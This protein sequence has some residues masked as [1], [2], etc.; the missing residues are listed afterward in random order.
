MTNNSPK[1]EVIATLRQIKTYAM[2]LA[3]SIRRPRF[4]YQA[5]G[6]KITF[7]IEDESHEIDPKLV[8][9]PRWKLMPKEITDGF[10]SIEA[11]ARVLI[12]TFGLRFPA[13][14]GLHLLPLS[15]VGLV[16]DQLD[17]YR[18]EFY[19]HRDNFL[20][21]LDNIKEEIREQLPEPIFN[22][23]WA[24]VPSRERLKGLFNIYC[25]TVPLGDSDVDPVILKTQM[26]L[27]DSLIADA[28]PQCEERL[29]RLQTFLQSLADP[30]KAY[31]HVFDAETKFRVQQAESYLRDNLRQF[32]DTL[33][34]EPRNV[35]KK[36]VLHLIDS[37][38]EEKII[39]K[40]TLAKI[41]QAFSMAE[42]FSFMNP[43]LQHII[44]EGRELLS[45]YTPR[46]INKQQLLSANL[47]SS[48][49]GLLERTM[50]PNVILSATNNFRRICT[51][52]AKLT[53]GTL[54]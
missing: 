41:E 18:Q 14:R 13:I 3:V 51:D 45:G 2:W 4:N 6:A 42:G 15:K 20:D 23:V 22:N 7:D 11:K 24:K 36:A 53:Q 12:S 46:D 44:Q 5:D 21:N 52:A 8:A 29:L 10:G 19:G 1:S 17:V 27:V 35:I 16:Y 32:V 48:L 30:V 25:T 31:A 40:G 39:K 50:N 54:S 28:P 43:D 47:A 37:I 9:I 26:H 33:A 38:K 49:E 34:T